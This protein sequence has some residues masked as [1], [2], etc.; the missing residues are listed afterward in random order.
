MADPQTLAASHS[1]EVWTAFC[2]AV[3]IIGGLVTVLYNNMS[4][5][6]KDNSTRLDNGQK[7]FE[8]LKIEQGKINEQIKA[9]KEEDEFENEELDRLDTTL[10]GLNDRLNTLET[11]HK[12]CM[13]RKLA[14]RGKT[15]MEDA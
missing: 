8:A 5:S 11:E 10:R 13:P 15:L 9:L 3:T 7:E 14:M 2:G 6:I 4:K 1:A 12:N